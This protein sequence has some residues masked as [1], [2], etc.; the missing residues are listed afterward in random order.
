MPYRYANTDIIV[1][2][3]MGVLGATM[4]QSATHNMLTS[5]GASLIGSAVNTHLL[6]S[7]ERFLSGETALSTVLITGSSALAHMITDAL[8]HKHHK[9]EMKIEIQHAPCKQSWTERAEAQQQDTILTR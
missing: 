7:Q 4:N 6:K 5:A 3:I 2:G 8:I 1:G 9:P